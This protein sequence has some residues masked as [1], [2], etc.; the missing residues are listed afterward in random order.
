MRASA[1]TRTISMHFWV[2]REMKTRDSTS[3]IPPERKR[4]VEGWRL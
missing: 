3:S 4:S 1:A 2:C